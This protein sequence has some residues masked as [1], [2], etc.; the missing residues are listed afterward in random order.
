[1]AG[2]LLV[3][4]QTLSFTWDETFHLLAAQLILRGKVPYLDFCFP[5]TPL[6][7]YF[8]AACMWL[9]GE[10][11][12]TAHAF[13]ALFTAGTGTLAAV[14]AYRRVADPRFRCVAAC[15]VALLVGLNNLVFDFGTLG[16]AY[17]LCLFAVMAGFLATTA[18]A[19][20]EGVGFAALA[21]LAAGVAAASSLLTAVAA[22]TLW[23]WLALANR[24]G[25]RW[26]KLAAFAAS[27][28][29]PFL[30]VLRLYLMGPRQT[31]FNLFQY[32]LLY[33]TSA[34]SDPG[35]HDLEVFSS[36]VDS[37]QA[38]LLVG[39]AGAG[40]IALA[41]GVGWDRARRSEGL[42]CAALGGALALE[43]ATAHPTFERYFLLAV[44]Y[45]AIL[46]GLGLRHSLAEATRPR[47]IAAA[48]AALLA[49]TWAKSL[50]SRQDIYTWNDMEQVARKTAE[51]AP[52]NA[53]LWADE[54]I[55]FLL[56]RTP[57]S[58]MEFA[59]S[60]KLEG[61][62]AGRAAELRILPFSEIGRRMAAGRYG[63]VETCDDETEAMKSFKLA[64]RFQK[65]TEVADC[66]VYSEKRP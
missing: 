50:Q 65:R 51:L 61:L 40:L 49:A 5:Q 7:A 47:L 8:T 3:Y 28:A 46:A 21:G 13:A 58:G 59:Y 32:H 16:Q 4:S 36:L 62:A 55:Y 24:A 38:L 14:Y 30:P 12:R 39:L 56:R 45:L 63:V 31:V 33:R 43:A 25:S 37:G 42:L 19:R 44:P 60:H 53:F 35:S 34:W 15:G 2:W 20:R 9:F 57:P 41:S 29:I 18:A 26:R 11:W 52:A 64:E 17:G 54:P 23:I 6:N 66:V 1:M 27:C 10:S 48:M 22:P